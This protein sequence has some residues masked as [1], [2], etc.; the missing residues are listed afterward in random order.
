[1]VA[2][3]FDKRSLS[4]LSGFCLVFNHYNI[5]EKYLALGVEF[6]VYTF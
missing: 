5:D 2:W 1:M 3:D 6:K 4:L